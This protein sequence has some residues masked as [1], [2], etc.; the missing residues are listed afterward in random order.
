MGRF[1]VHSGYT[2]NLTPSGRLEVDTWSRWLL[3]ESEG[4]EVDHHLVWELL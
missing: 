4:T 1:G 3:I 2:T